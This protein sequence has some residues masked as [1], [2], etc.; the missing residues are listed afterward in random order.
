[1]LKGQDLCLI[2]KSELKGKDVNKIRKKVIKKTKDFL[3]TD[4]ES[5]IEI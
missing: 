1:M 5:F 4:A 3:T 2:I